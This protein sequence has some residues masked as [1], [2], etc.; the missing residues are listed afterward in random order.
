MRTFPWATM[1]CCGLLLMWAPSASG[2]APE[3]FLRVKKTLAEA[4]QKNPLPPP[5]TLETIV[6]IA[7][8]FDDGVINPALWTVIAGSPVEQGG[9]LSLNVTSTDSIITVSLAAA[10]PLAAEDVVVTIDFA[11]FNSTGAGDAGLYLYTDTFSAELTLTE[12]GGR[13]AMLYALNDYSQEVHYSLPTAATTGSLRLIYHRNT[14]VLEGLLREGATWVRVGDTTGVALGI[15]TSINAALFAIVTD[16]TSVS[17][18]F[19]N[20]LAQ[21]VTADPVTAVHRRLWTLYEK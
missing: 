19:D 21:T 10:L 4:R 5:R 12:D 6:S 20:F 3:S 1:A 15:V 11:S 8:D 17:I 9:V 18:T 14:G 16:D 7:D 2:Q 13:Q